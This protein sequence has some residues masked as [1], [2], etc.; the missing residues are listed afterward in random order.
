M[1]PETQHLEHWCSVESDYANAKF[2]PAQRERHDDTLRQYNLDFWIPQVQ[3]YFGRARA[4][5]TGA[6]E[7]RMGSMT[8]EDEEKAIHLEKMAE[9]AVCKA[10]MT[11]QGFAESMIRVFGELP[12]PGLSSG[13]VEPW[14]ESTYEKVPNQ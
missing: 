5:I 3:Q 12:K 13:Y 4:F 10:F 14:E 2:D 6:L 1:R 11:A 7:L 9:Q 8:P